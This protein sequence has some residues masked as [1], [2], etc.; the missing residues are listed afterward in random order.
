MIFLWTKRALSSGKLDVVVKSLNLRTF[1][2]GTTIEKKL[3]VEVTA[4]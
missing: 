2:S 3:F 1:K 4:G